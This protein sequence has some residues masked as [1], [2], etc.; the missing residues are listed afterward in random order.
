MGSRSHPHRVLSV[1]VCVC[2][3][4]CLWVCV[5]EADSLRLRVITVGLYLFL[6]RSLLCQILAVFAVVVYGP[7]WFRDS[8]ALLLPGLRSP[9]LGCP[10]LPCATRLSP[11]ESSASA[12]GKLRFCLRKLRL[13]P[14][15]SSV[16]AYGSSASA[17]RKAPLLPTEAP[18]LPYGKLRLVSRCVLLPVINSLSA[19][20]SSRLHCDTYFIRE[21]PCYMTVT[22]SRPWTQNGRCVLLLLYFSTNTI[23]DASAYPMAFTLGRFYQ[24]IWRFFIWVHLFSV[25]FIGLAPKCEASGWM[26]PPQG[27]TLTS[28]FLALQWGTSAELLFRTWLQMSWQKNE[29]LL[30][31][32][33]IWFAYHALY[34]STSLLS[35]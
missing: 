3:S 4:R 35:K 14:T 27:R 22:I 12:Y 13:C 32:I 9:D 24:S 15:E 18:P 11:T 34:I 20:E 1:C 30:H 25:L 2:V 17:L 26:K 29:Y 33:V 6:S 7:F 23:C 16:S 31:C 10:L 8:W 28:K 21:S 19:T 5:I